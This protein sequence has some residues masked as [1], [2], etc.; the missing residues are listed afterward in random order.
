MSKYIFNYE[1]ISY[2]ILMIWFAVGRFYNFKLLSCPT[3]QIVLSPP[4]VVATDITLSERRF[5]RHN[6]LVI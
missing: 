5:D 3:T 4:A 2:K 6:L 1:K